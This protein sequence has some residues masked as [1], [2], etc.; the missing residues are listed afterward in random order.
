[1]NYFHFAIASLVDAN[2]GHGLVHNTDKIDYA[3]AASHGRQIRAKSMVALL[4]Q[5]KRRLSEA[6]VSIRER[7]AQ[8]RNLHHLARLNDHLLE[9]IGMS[10]GDVIALQMGQIDLRQL[11]A[12]REKNR[13]ATRLL[14]AAITRS[15]GNT[16]RHN[17]FNEAVFARAKCA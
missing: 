4:G 7:Q 8:K 2:T 14:P 13:S 1:M 6:V 3:A 9:D 11:E 16:I 10:R 15:V 12:R 5:V 17:A